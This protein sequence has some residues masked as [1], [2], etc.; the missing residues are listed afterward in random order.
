MDR[1]LKFT[2]DF[3]QGIL[4]TNTTKREGEKEVS[5]LQNTRSSK[6]KLARLI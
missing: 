1:K 6:G 3:R 4:E 5:D 2:M